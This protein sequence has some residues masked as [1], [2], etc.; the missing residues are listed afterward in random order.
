MKK[1]EIKEL[2]VQSV[3]VLEKKLAELRK[4]QLEAAVNISAGRERNVRTAKNLRREIAQVMT[5]INEKKQKGG[6]EK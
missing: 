6:K 3:E 5:V 1:R 4:K 2:R